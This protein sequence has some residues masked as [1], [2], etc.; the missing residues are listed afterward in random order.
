M[1]TYAE[2]KIFVLDTKIDLTDAC[3]HSYV[4][5]KSHLRGESKCSL[6]HFRSPGAWANSL[7]NC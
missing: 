4:T 1:G 6:P 3:S 2:L 5:E 7:L